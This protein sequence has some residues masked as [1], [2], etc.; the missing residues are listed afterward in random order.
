[1]IRKVPPW[2]ARL[3]EE[4]RERGWT[5]REMAK[6]LAD[7]ASGDVRLPERDSLIR[8]IK[9]WEAGN[10]RPKDP[11]PV[12]YARVFGLDE[13]DLFEGGHRATPDAVAHSFPASPHR[14]VA[15]E[16]VDY[17]RL[18]LLSHYAADAFL[19]PRHL[20][21]TVAV[22]YQSITELA[23]QADGEVQRELLR[24]GAGFAAFAGWLCQDAGMTGRAAVWLNA[25]L[26]MAHRAQ[27]VQLVSHALTNKAMLAADLGDAA[28][29]IGLT[30]A[31]LSDRGKLM[32]KTQVLALQQGAHG[33]ALA[34]DRARC[35]ALLDQAAAII[36][37]IDDDHMWGNACRTPNYVEIQRATCYGRLGLTTDAVVLW[38]QILPSMPV[39][40]RRD[41]GVFLARQSAALATI[42]EPER[43]TDAARKAIELLHQTGSI[44]QRAELAAVSARMGAWVDT[45]QGREM[46]EMLA[47][48]T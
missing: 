46:A 38:D 48:V 16:L 5:Q 42:P 29:V 45:A 34:S 17:F 4:R 20:I 43:A 32:P 36:D 31:A 15:P 12:L 7:A 30:A 21:A 18:Q 28:A 23:G 44:R 25:N 8:R 19:G 14:H 33:Y 24:L 10:H 9:D 3:R 27:D 40:A 1:M 11:Y 26:E 35:D 2:A 47:G 22:Q 13:A 41:I 37:D 6:R 39:T